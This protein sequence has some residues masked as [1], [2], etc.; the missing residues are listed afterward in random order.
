[1]RVITGET[2]VVAIPAEVAEDAPAEPAVTDTAELAEASTHE[3]AAEPEVDVDDL[4]ARIKA[5]RAETVAKA[6]EVLAEPAPE[7]DTE[8]ASEPAADAEPEVAVVV[9]EVVVETDDGEEVAVA[10]VVVE[11]SP[12]EPDDQALLER[13][14]GLL[15]PIEARLTKAL[16]RAMADEQNDVL[17]KLRRS[18][19]KDLDAV[20]PVAVAQLE[21]YAEPLKAE[22]AVAADAGASFAGEER[23]G[24][25]VDA[26]AADLASSIVTPMRERITTALH[27]ANG[28]EE[29]GA[30]GVRACYR[31]WKSQRLGALVNDAA[32]TAFNRG[33]FDTVEGGT[34]LRWLVD[35]GGSPCP[36]AED[37]ALAG[38]VPCGEPFP[39]GHGHPPAH[40]GCRCMIVPTPA[41]D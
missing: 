13:R 22:L 31:E 39:T 41:V 36:D 4:F 19:G 11:N 21:R 27:D 30:D 35:N 10:V 12:P 9:E 32:L 1:M 18:K 3:A 38:L 17:D 5:A 25:N 33:V 26:V 2:P 37:N 29:A 6:E 23:S 28:D 34:P 20:L 40:P 14:D 8:P 16:K 15:E 24:P 7:P